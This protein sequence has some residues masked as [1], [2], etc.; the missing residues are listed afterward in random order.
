[1][2]KVC[3]GISCLV[4]LLNSA[5]ISTSVATSTVPYIYTNNPSA[6][7][8]ILGE[9][10]L[11]SREHVGYIE[12]LR[13]ARRLYPNCDYV[14]DIMMDQRITTTTTTT[15]LWVF[16]PFLRRVE[17]AATDIIWIMRGTAIMYIR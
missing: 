16:L 13:A 8:V 7:F 17:S 5:C 15:T 9:V 12:L 6:D 14:I 11:E 2:K 10:L 3:F 4:L 1:M